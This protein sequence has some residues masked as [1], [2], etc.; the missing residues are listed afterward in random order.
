M[1][2]VKIIIK[3]SFLFYESNHIRPL[4]FDFRG[5]SIFNKFDTDS[6][7][8]GFNW[9]TSLFLGSFERS[10]T[11]LSGQLLGFSDLK[12]SPFPPLPNFAP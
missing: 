5:F 8:N 2:E 12:K 4:L 3:G 9:L 11:K 6:C 10:W 1:P 7:R